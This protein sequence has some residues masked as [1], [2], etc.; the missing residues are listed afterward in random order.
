MGL[1]IGDI[2]AVLLLVGP[3]ALAMFVHH[4]STQQLFTAEPPMPPAGAPERDA[5][6]IAGEET[7]ALIAG[8]PA[9]VVEPPA[10]VAD[11]FAEITGRMP[12]LDDY[13][14]LAIF[15]LRPE[16]TQ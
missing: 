14:G 1:L 6:S 8:T 12:E 16:V 9:T 4:L 7:V 13:D 2:L 5:D 3:C 15:Y 11:Q 10:S